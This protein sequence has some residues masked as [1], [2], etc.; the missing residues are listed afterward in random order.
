[1][2]NIEGKISGEVND[3]KIGA[4]E[5]VAHISQNRGELF[6]TIGPVNKAFGH[7]FQM[8]PTL[9][10]LLGWLFGKSINGKTGY[11][12]VGNRFKSTSI[13]IFKTGKG[14]LVYNSL[15]VIHLVRNLRHLNVNA[16]I[17]LE[18]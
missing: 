9:T 2:I 13:I 15:R 1:M 6:V 18:E 8:V 14:F 12:I 17:H 7:S 11:D 16:I 10:G 3:I 5:M 4:A